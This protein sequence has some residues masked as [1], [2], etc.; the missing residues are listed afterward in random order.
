MT[1]TP[2]VAVPPVPTL[3]MKA[4]E[5]FA[6][7][8]GVVPNVLTLRVGVNTGSKDNRGVADIAT[9]PLSHAPKLFVAPVGG[10]SHTTL[11]ALV[12][13]E[14]TPTIVST[15]SPAYDVTVASADVARPRVGL[16]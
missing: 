14:V 16:M 11:A 8:V 13:P 1:T 4:C 10:A 12:T 2:E 7:I 3:M 15:C 9:D 5:P 6:M